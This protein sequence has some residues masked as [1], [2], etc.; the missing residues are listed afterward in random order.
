LVS[1]E[2]VLYCPKERLNMARNKR[3]KLYK[4]AVPYGTIENEFIVPFN[5]INILE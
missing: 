5:P 1:K 2:Y 4:Y 3:K